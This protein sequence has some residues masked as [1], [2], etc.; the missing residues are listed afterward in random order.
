MSFK[1]LKVRW[2]PLKRFPK[3]DSSAAAQS[4]PSVAPLPAA[5]V[6]PYQSLGSLRSCDIY[7]VLEAPNPESFK[8]R[9][10]A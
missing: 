1:G 3:P 4:T 8:R 9:K 2:F 10:P 6:L 5:P 7:Y